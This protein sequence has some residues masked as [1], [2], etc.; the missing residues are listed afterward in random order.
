MSVSAG[1]GGTTLVGVMVGGGAVAHGDVASPATVASTLPFTG[2]SHVMLLVAIGV[3]LLV[4][5]L[6]AVGLV[7]RPADGD[8]S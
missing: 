7:R 2:A 4:A 3:V 6:L 1:T 5:G 8:S